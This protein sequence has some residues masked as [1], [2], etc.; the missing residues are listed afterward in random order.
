MAD[1]KPLYGR[2]VTLEPMNILHRN[3]IVTAASD[4][5][6]WDLNF[7]V[8]PGESTVDKFLA[9]ALQGQLEGTVLPY[10]IMVGGTVIG[11]T[12][13]WKL[14][15][16][17]RNAEIGRTWIA[18]RYQGTVVN[19]E[20]KFLM[21]QYAF[22]SLELIRVQFTTD[23]LNIH[24]QR[25]ILRLGAVEEGIIRNERIMPDGRFR[26]SARY[27][28]IESEWPLVK[29]YLHEKMQQRAVQDPL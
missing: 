10:V 3:E 18:K 16:Q 25:A 17:N 24:S 12:R 21:L 2:T 11:S 26:H 20:A 15:L 5:A 29:K 19:T 22:E 23:V 13:F 8:V 9:E 27:S 7:T 28:I 14:D 1:I 6:L 4:G